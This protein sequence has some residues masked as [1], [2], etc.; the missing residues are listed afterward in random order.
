MAKIWKLITMEELMNVFCII[1]LLGVVKLPERRM[2]WSNNDELRISFIIKNYH[3]GMGGTDGR[4]K[5]VAYYKSRGSQEEEV[6]DV[7]LYL[8][9]WMRT[10]CSS[11][12]TSPQAHTHRPAIHSETIRRLHCARLVQQKRQ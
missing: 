11:W 7:Y 5:L 8:P 2:A 12:I 4:N 9:S 10:L 3:R 6:A 1:L